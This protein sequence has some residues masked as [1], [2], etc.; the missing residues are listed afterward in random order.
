MYA[1]LFLALHIISARTGLLG[2]W[3]GILI[4]V[5]SVLKSNEALRKINPW[6]AIG[7]VLVVLVLLLQIPSLKNRIVNTGEDLTALFNGGNINHKS[8]GQ[9]VEAWKATSG[10]IKESH[11][12]WSGVG[13]AQFDAQLQESYERQ[14][15]SL[16]VSNRIGPH[17][18]ILQWMA[19]YGVFAVIAWFALITTLLLRQLGPTAALMI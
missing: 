7:G 18:Q 14:K 16:F 1:L 3:L 8:I 17:N 10:I 5:L 13:T 11:N 4:W 15:T 19:T 9:R 2:Y 12:F 6:V